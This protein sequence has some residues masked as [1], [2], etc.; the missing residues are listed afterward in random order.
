MSEIVNAS[1]ATAQ[2]AVPVRI[3]PD[4]IR[5]LNDNFEVCGLMYTHPLKCIACLRDE[6]QVFYRCSLPAQDLEDL[7]NKTAVLVEEAPASPPFDF[8]WESHMDMLLSGTP[9]EVV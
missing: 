5:E 4:E 9:Q 3:S 2:V 7:C 1:A 6:P 8:T